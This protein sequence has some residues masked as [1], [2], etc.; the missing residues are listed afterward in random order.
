M[1]VR[2]V[3]SNR[4]KFR[5]VAEIL[6]PFGIQSSWTRRALPE[7]Q[8]DRLELVIRSKLDA[9]PRDGRTY[10]VEDSGLFLEGLGGFPGVY[11]AYIYRTIGLAGILRLLQGRSRSAVFRTLA[12]VR[13]GRS[14]W[15]VTGATKGTIA[16]KLRGEGG[17]GYDPIFVPSGERRSFAEMSL[18]EKNR[19]SHR[20][21]AIRRAG[22]RLVGSPP[23]P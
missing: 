12:G 21:K 17:F 13:R 22:A 2:F 20:G 23:K 14:S 4:D 10:L 1:D 16:S 5:E 7:P 11:S 18:A 9:L 6:R 8:A 19:F 3:S 15:W